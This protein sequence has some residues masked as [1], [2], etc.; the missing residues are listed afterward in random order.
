MTIWSQ[1][2]A[3]SFSFCRWAYFY[4]DIVMVKFK[5][6]PINIINIKYC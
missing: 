3:N 4:F 1:I 6:D 5:A 2:R